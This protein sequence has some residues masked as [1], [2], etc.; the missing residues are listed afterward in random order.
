[1]SG[2][3]FSLALEA[4]AIFFV[5]VCIKVMDD[6]VDIELDTL[7]DKKTLA[8]KL[9][10]GTLPYLLLLFAVAAAIN[11]EL[12]LALFMASYAVG[13]Y[14]DL[15]RPLPTGLK[16]WQESAVVFGLGIALVGWVTIVWSFAI[17][18]VIQLLDDLIDYRL[19]LKTGVVKAVQRLGF[20][21][22]AL[23]VLILTLLSLYLAVKQTLMV[24][25]LTPV[26]KW[27][28][29]KAGQEG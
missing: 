8:A 7:L 17:M 3:I 25:C 9:G 22:T 27:L 14:Q 12:T 13:M 18:A 2:A 21:E 11:Q 15:F 1:M 20:T 24:L 5:G 29:A 28:V 6:Y 10:P 16:G 4:L 26:V 19:D 23:L